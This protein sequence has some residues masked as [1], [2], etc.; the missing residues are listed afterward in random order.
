MKSCQIKGLSFKVS[1]VSKI[2]MKQAISENE[3]SF[4]EEK[5]LLILILLQ[6]ELNLSIYLSI[7]LSVCLSVC[8]SINLSIV[9]LK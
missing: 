3:S 7:Y 4:Q 9:A 5:E 2:F 6:Q 8:L 1:L